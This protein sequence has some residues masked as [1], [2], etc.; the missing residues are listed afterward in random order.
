[1]DRKRDIFLFK[2]YK[3]NIN[4]L[5]SVYEPSVFVFLYWKYEFVKKLGLSLSARMDAHE[6]LAFKFYFKDCTHWYFNKK[7]LSKPTLPYLNFFSYLG[8]MS[9]HFKC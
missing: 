7:K 6:T 4:L 8:K 1:M 9:F 3:K 2:K 5:R